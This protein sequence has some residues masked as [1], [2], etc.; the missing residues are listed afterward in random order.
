MTAASMPQETRVP[1]ACHHAS[2]GSLL[3]CRVSAHL[4]AKVSSC[5]G[6]CRSAERS[7]METR[8]L[9]SASTAYASQTR[10]WCTGEVSWLLVSGA[11]TTMRRRVWPCH[12]AT[13]PRCKTPDSPRTECAYGPCCCCSRSAAARCGHSRGSSGTAGTTELRSGT[14]PCR[15][16]WM[17]CALSAF[18]FK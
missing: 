3:D 8:T 4:G 16:E 18:H 15:S 12:E 17:V 10:C 1:W 5:R 13:R 7:S 6:Q 14:T 9:V 11:A 2:A